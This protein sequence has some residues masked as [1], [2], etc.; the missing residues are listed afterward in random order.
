MSPS[1]PDPALNP[2][3]TARHLSQTADR[4]VRCGLCLPHCPTYREARQEAES[5]RGRIALIQGWAEGG[6]DASPRLLDHLDNCLECLACERACPTLVPFGDLMDE[7]RAAT[8]RLAPAWRRIPRAAWLT[9]LASRAGA[10][11][12]VG[13][14]RLYRGSGLARL[15]TWGG[16]RRWPSLAALHR[17]A[18]QFERLP[19]L[20]AS[21][22]ARPESGDR[23]GLFL[24]CIA[25]AAQPGAIEASMRVLRVLGLEIEV[26]DDQTCC[27]A[28]HRHNGLPEGADQR[29]RRN[30]AAFDGL[31][32]VG[33]ASACVA[34]LRGHPPLGATQDLCRLLA[35]RD[36]PATVHLAPLPQRVAVH[37]PCSQ[38]NRLGDEDAA[39]ALLRRIP[40]ISLV[41]LPDNAFCCGAAGTYLLQRPVLSRVL[42]APKIASLAA[43]Q[44]PILVTTNTGCALHLAAGAQEAGLQVEVLH[45]VELIDR[46][47]R[48]T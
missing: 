37:V 10:T 16:I 48:F 36:W 15:A 4:C 35:D 30:A 32:P 1:P 41:P 23:I 42:L 27:G 17:L 21:Q 29:L 38:R 7:A 22:P 3:D 20:P 12:A 13:W 8:W 47:M 9:V 6:L 26:P 43:I 14:G 28:L 40:G 19:R 11:L 18:I 33:L 44:A 2:A 5:P 39:F 45:P 34:E 46:Q 31:T 24:G 25:R